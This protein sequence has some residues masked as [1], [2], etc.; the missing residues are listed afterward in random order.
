MYVYLLATM[1]RP[2]D[3]VVKVKQPDNPDTADAAATDDGK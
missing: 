2:H 1:G 3:L